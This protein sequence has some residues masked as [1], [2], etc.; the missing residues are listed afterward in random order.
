MCCLWGN[1]HQLQGRWLFFG[2]L[3]L[4]CP[5]TLSPPQLGGPSSPQ[6]FLLLLCATKGD[7]CVALMR[8]VVWFTLVWAS[9]RVRCLMVMF[10][11]ILL[12]LL[13]LLCLRQVRSCCV[14]FLSLLVVE[15]LATLWLQLFVIYG[16]PQNYVKLFLVSLKNGVI[17]SMNSGGI[18]PPPLR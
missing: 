7:N 15:V 8:Q 12:L 17:E 6:G 9:R 3:Q 13:L 14:C 4:T 2:K 1:R 5:L 18:S 11:G 10:S 16:L